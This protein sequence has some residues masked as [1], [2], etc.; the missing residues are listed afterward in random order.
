M[1]VE[2]FYLYSTACTKLSVLIF[3]RRLVEGT[4]SRGFKLVIWCAIA[5]VLAQTIVFSVLV[6]MTCSPAPMIWYQYVPQ[7]VAAHPG[8]TCSPTR[9]TVGISYLS[10]SV[11]VFSDFFSVLL[12]GALLL[13]IQIS[14][15]Q[16]WG[17]MVIFGVGFLYGSTLFFDPVLTLAASAVPELGE[18]FIW[19]E[20]SEPETSRRTHTMPS[21]GR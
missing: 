9:I 5:F 7:W 8:A 15:R 17:L 20:Q 21:Y 19:V 10:G 2:Y 4:V 18:R 14:K 3:H 11:S 13:K 16:K 12:P 6:L 1:I